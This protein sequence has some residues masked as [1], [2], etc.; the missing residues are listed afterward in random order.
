MDLNFEKTSRISVIRVGIYTAVAI[1]VAASG[2]AAYSVLRKSETPT[3]PSTTIDW[4][5]QGGKLDANVPA[6]RVTVPATT[7]TTEPEETSTQPD[8]LPFTG[9]FALPLG[10]EILKDYSNG[11]M[12][13]SKTMGDWRVHNGIDFTG[14]ENSEVLAIQSGTVTAVYSD[15]MWGTVVEVDHGN[16]MTAKYCGFKKGT[17]VQKGDT[18]KKGSP[19]GKLGEIPI[20]KADGYHLHLEITVNSQTVDP[21]AAINRAS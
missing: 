18:V 13:S 4:D 15:D 1:C 7:V 20:E 21:L 17:T 11:E 16:T 6:T 3:L 14:T 2:I 8:N 12:V 10:T 9:S 19:L 5:N